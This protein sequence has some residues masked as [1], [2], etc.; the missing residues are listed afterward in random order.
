M[1]KRTLLIMFLALIGLLSVQA[2]A[3]AAPA[4]FRNAGGTH[5]IYMCRDWQA[6]PGDGRNEKGTCKTGSPRRALYPGQRT[7]TAFGWSDTDGFYLPN[8][9]RVALAPYPSTAY[10]VRY[11]SWGWRKVYGCYC[12]YNIKK[13]VP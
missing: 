6:S 11:K 4:T 5:A 2:P 7:S 8:G 10:F 12:T 1:I 3:L 9:Y 13:Y